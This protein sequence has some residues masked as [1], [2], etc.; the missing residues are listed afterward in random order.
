MAD[1]LTRAQF[2]DAGARMRQS[3]EALAQRIRSTWSHVLYPVPAQESANG[4]GPAAGFTLEHTSVVNRT[5]SKPI[6]QVVYEKLR[7]KGAIVDELGPDTLLTELRKVW[8]ED[9][10]HIEVA[11]LLDWFASYVY[12]PRL[13]D[14]ASLIHAIEKLIGKLYGAVAFA[15]SFDPQTGRYEG[16]S[17]WAANLGTNVASGLLVWRSALPVPAEWRL[18]R[19]Q[20]ASS[21]FRHTSFATDGVAITPPSRTRRSHTVCR[22]QGLVSSRSDVARSGHPRTRAPAAGRYGPKARVQFT[23]LSSIH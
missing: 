21:C 14:D 19:F 23:P 9:K 20:A 3:A 4:S 22:R 17:R 13:R 6:P 11:T 2:D 7:T 8:P 10:P 16:L 15:Q 5:P 12:L 18:R 1:G